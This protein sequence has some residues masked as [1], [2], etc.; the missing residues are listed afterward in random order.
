MLNKGNYFIK[1]TDV[2]V[3][4]TSVWL[5]RRNKAKQVAHRSA[6]YLFLVSFF[7]PY[8]SGQFFKFGNVVL[9]ACI[10]N[11]KV[12]ELSCKVIVVCSHVY[13]SVA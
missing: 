8:L 3:C 13:Q 7:A 11:F 12:G 6:D 9:N 1:I 2:V 4:I 5:S 10:G